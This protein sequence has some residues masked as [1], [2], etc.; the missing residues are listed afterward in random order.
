MNLNFNLLETNLVNLAIVIGVLFW[1]LRGFLGG[2]LER[3]RSAILQDL[4]DAE[5]RLK[6]ATEE[7]TK[8]Q[9]ELAAAQ[10]KAEQ[11]RVDGQKRAAA[12]RVEGEKRTISVMAAIKQGASADADAEASRIKDALRREAALAAIDK[13]LTDLPGRLDDA[14]QSQLIDSTIRNL[15]NA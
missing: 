7:L 5:A 3:R 8:A 11:I 10:Q 15:E 2:I 12:I 14:A 6:T 9:S 1:F 4:Q 13:V